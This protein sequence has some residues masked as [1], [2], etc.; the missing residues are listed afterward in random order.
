MA[1]V[2]GPIST[3]PGT[4]RQ[5]PDGVACDEHPDRPAVAR[6]QGETDSFGCEMHDLCAECLAAFRAHA[7]SPEARSGDCDWCR[8]A[9]T[10]LSE[11]RDSD[12]G[13]YGPVYLVCGAC[14]RKDDEVMR[15]ESAWGDDFYDDPYDDPWQDDEP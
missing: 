5:P 3:L 9:A 13:L 4:A 2:T 8:Q 6:V 12:E 7:N 10:D 11:R 1:E 15:E 14:R